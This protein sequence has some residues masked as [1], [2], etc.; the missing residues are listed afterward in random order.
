MKRFLLDL[1]AAIAASSAA[2]QACEPG[3]ANVV[4]CKIG[5]KALQVCAGSGQASYAYGPTGAPELAI[6]QRLEEV[7][8][9]AWNGVGRSIW[10][11]IGFRNNEVTYTV[12]AAIDRLEEGNPM[13]GGVVVS[14]GETV[15]ADLQCQAGTAQVS[16]FAVSEAF[17]AAGYCWD[18][19]AERYTTSC[20][21]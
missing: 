15:L 11:E 4:S 12:W 2:A 20:D 5:S 3:L 14:R 8:A 1:G 7:E 17:Q 9:R 6:T 13:S 18:R 21:N 16:T 10:E 19:A